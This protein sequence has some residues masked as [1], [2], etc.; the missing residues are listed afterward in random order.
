[1]NVTGLPK[2]EEIPR[3]IVPPCW[4]SEGGCRPLSYWCRPPRR[5]SRPDEA[6]RSLGKTEKTMMRIWNKMMMRMLN[7]ALAR[8][9]KM[10]VPLEC[11]YEWQ[12]KPVLGPVYNPAPIPESARTYL[13]KDNPRL[14]D[15]QRR[16]AKCDSM[17]IVSATWTD[18]Y[19]RAED[20]RYFRG[21]NIYVW[22]VRGGPYTAG[23][24][25]HEMGQALAAHYAKFI[26][27]AGLFDRLAEDGAFGAFMFDVAG[28][29]VS[30]DL[31]DSV[32]ELDFLDRHLD[33][34]RRSNV[35]ILD[36][37]AGYGRLAYRTTMAAPGVRQYLCVDAIAHS[38]FLSE[39]YLAYRAADRTRVVPLD[40]VAATL[41][42]EQID[43]AININS[44][45]ECRVEAIEWWVS[46]TARWGVR[47]F[48][49]SCMSDEL[50][51]NHGVEFSSIFARHRYRLVVRE[52]K[53]RDPPV[54]R[55]AIAP[56]YYFLF[57]LQ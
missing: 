2:T 16:Y 39:F 45:S 48:M 50:R 14:L 42:A 53:Y 57:E 30:R 9:G 8:R 49:V 44:F 24:N 5:S 26:D 40:E 17:V 31:T 15:L 10:I 18:D 34:L 46:R 41:G 51:T 13:S 27:R 38:T 43:I 36:I 11:L 29:T 20:L 21:D 54:Q 37:G 7:S 3:Y 22:Q 55:Y 33:L 28:R 47:R 19:L 35:S 52:P 6:Q 4:A 12:R 56:G 23:G 25:Y 1:V 32:I